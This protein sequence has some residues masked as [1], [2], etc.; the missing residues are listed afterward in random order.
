MTMQK[1]FNHSRYKAFYLNNT[2]KP[3]FISTQFKSNPGLGHPFDGPRST[4]PIKLSMLVNFDLFVK[5][6][7]L[8]A[9]KT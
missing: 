4:S 3:R 8:F 2:V 9:G 1:C 5:S 6:E 7:S